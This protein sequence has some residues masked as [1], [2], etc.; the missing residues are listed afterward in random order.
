M[1]CNQIAADSEAFWSNVPD[2]NL[3][4]F[5]RIGLPKALY[6]PETTAFIEKYTAK[7]GKAEAESYAMEAYDSLKL[8]AQAINEA[9]ATDGDSVINA[10]ENIS[11][12]GA[13]GTVTF[14]YGVNN[15]VPEDMAAKWWHQF[16]DPAIT[17][18]QYQA[19]GQDVADA[20]VVFPDTYKTADPIL[21][22]R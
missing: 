3:C 8:M 1:L 2:G 22:G 17:L 15:P 9:G 21:A 11:Y 20:S 7:T 6:T 16:P 12:N 10:L 18:V 5:T 13:L 14:P 19:V 4:I